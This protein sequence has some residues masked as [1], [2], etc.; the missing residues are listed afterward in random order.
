MHVPALIGIGSLGALIAPLVLINPQQRFFMLFPLALLL[1]GYGLT[2]ILTAAVLFIMS[3]TARLTAVRAG[4]L[5]SATRTQSALL[6][7]LLMALA[8]LLSLLVTPQP[9]S[10]TP[11]HPITR[12]LNFLRA[13]VPPGSVIVG[14][15]LA[16]YAYYLSAEGIHLRPLSPADYPDSALVGAFEADPSLRYALLTGWY[17]QSVYDQWFAQWQAT[18]PQLPWTLAAQEHSPDLQLYVLPPHADGYG[19]VS[20]ALWLLQA[21][22]LGLDAATLPP[23]STLDFGQTLTWRSDNP[24][25]YV[26][27]IV[28][29][30][31]NLP[32]SC[33]VMHPY[34]PG[35][36]EYR[37]VSSQVET[38]IPSGWSGRSLLFF[39][40]LAPWA[41]S[42][43]D[44]Q[45]T[46]LTFAIPQMGYSQVVE[47]LNEP[48]QH[49]MPIMVN[50][51][52]NTSLAT[53]TITIQPRVSI[54]DDTTLLSY[55]GVTQ[56]SQ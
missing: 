14:E 25:H 51:P 12:T 26:Q 45:G 41:A 43:P 37:D 19:Q 47:V 24:G 35:L 10:T 17:S 40:T 39:A 16:S 50:L 2:L 56:P 53:L 42:Q 28:R 5:A 22:Q 20:Y 13:H 33:F 49:W 30:A 36:D 38:R 6:A 11:P 32:V 8:F 21:K 3:L 23:F 4:G 52:A 29:S 9:Y 34:Y 55:V 46:K 54:S 1:V 27:P 44:A 48:Q 18:F 15:P 31:W 7:L